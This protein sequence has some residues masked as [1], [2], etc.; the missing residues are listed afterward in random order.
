MPLVRR[1]KVSEAQW[2]A[3]VTGSA[4]VTF[5]PRASGHLTVDHD[6]QV[7]PRRLDDHLIYLVLDE[8]AAGHVAGQPLRLEP[9]NLIWLSPGIAH[10]F[11]L[12]DRARPMT[13]YHLRFRLTVDDADL[14]V[15]PRWSIIE[16]GR[17]V[18]HEIDAIVHELRG[19]L[20][21]GLTRCRGLLAAMTATLFRLRQNADQ[22]PALDARQRRLIRQFVRDH[23]DTW[24]SPADLADAVG[25]SADYFTRLFRKTFSAPPRR[26]LMAERIRAAAALLAES[27]LTVTEVARRFG[28]KSV[29][30][31]SRQFKQITGRSPRAYRRS[32]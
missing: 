26:W 20:P 13:L 18:R 2:Q 29:Y 23:L 28:Y 14:L 32:P 3:A 27:N 6:W 24:P 21:H 16:D 12:A 5:N 11:E 10:R 30:L 9:H 7:G 17:E 15:A 22:P 1:Y 25:L 31:F 4:T 19:D 8:A